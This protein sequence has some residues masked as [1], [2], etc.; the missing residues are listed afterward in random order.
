[1][2]LI[3]FDL[4][5]TL[6]NKASVIS[7][8]TRE[9]LCLLRDRDIAYTVA[10]GR[11]LHASRKLLHGQNFTL[12]HIYKNGVMIW[13]PLQEDYSHKYMLSEHELATVLQVF[14]EQGVTPFIFTLTQDN[15]HAAYHATVQS[16][17]EV[18]FVEELSMNRELPLFPVSDLPAQA[19]ITNIS[20][21]G[22]RAAI[23][24]LT[25]SV[26]Q[27][28]HLVAYR[29]AGM[30]NT[31]IQWLDIHHSEGSKGAAVGQLKQRLGV[32]R[33]ICFGD[34]DN[35]LSMFACADE[36]YAPENS[37]AEVKDAATAVIGHHDQDGIAR[38]LR[39]RFSL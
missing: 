1:M 39:E 21:L 7:D 27:E 6:L 5:G 11:T 3:V 33:V 13:H 36:A 18:R 38:F 28:E 15:Q 14:V 32:S 37:L 10:T 19:Q 34:S 9:T 20:A 25:A 30:P 12:P 17:V 24:Q 22:P 23:D 35:D 4:D 8:Y 2:D 26:A 31:D 29:G 16:E